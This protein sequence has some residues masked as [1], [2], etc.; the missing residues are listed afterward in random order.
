MG[1]GDA[2]QRRAGGGAARGRIRA[3]QGL[4]RPA[5]AALLCFFIAACACGEELKKDPRAAYEV[6]DS[7]QQIEDLLKAAANAP[8]N[9]LQ[10]RE[11]LLYH[12][13]YES[14]RAGFSSDVD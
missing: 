14:F 4:V 10:L 3:M 2:A 8:Y 5:V 9:E 13:A 7:A 1:G 12:A 11:G 6:I